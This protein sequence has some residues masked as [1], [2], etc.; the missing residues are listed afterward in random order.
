MRNLQN[1]HKNEM[2]VTLS[3]TGGARFCATTDGYN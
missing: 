1:Y 3:V 2:L